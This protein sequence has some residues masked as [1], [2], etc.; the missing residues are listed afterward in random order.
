MRKN[1]LLFLIA[2]FSISAISLF[3]QSAAHHLHAPKLHK[4]SAVSTKSFFKN[5]AITKKATATNTNASMQYP[6]SDQNLQTSY[7]LAS[8]WYIESMNRL[9]TIKDTGSGANMNF[10]LTH[11]LTVAFDTVVDFYSNNTYIP[12]AGSLV[13]DTIT[14]F[15]AYSNTS[16]LND[17]LVFFITNVTANGYP[18]ST[19]LHTDTII[20]NKG[21][22]LPGNTIDSIYQ[23]GVLPN[24]VVASGYKFAVTMQFSG[25]KADTFAVG[26]AFPNATCV[27]SGGAYADAF[28]FFGP[29]FGPTPFC[30]SFVTGW[31]YYQTSPYA[32]VTWP[33]THGNQIGVLGG[34]PFDN[35]EWNLCGTDTEYFYWQDNAILTSVSFTDATGI[36]TISDNG[37]SISQNFPNPF[38][39]TTQISY[40]INK[41]SDIVF[42]VYDMTGRKLVSNSYSDIAPGKHQINLSANQFTPGIYFYTFDVNG[43]AVTRK[44]VITQ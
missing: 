22:N 13:V 24:F 39:Q 29:K 31:E 15:V 35:D 34:V 23:I 36:N 18:G 33:D 27:S 40:S 7:S 1:K 41:S 28:T 2:G 26:Y 6:M 5:T 8:G 17:T 11:S 3:A 38:N 10:D 14:S 42:S 25:S 37:L 9:W 19:V 32:P 30:N 4:V 43:K 20:L 16:G 12:A 21:K 44:M